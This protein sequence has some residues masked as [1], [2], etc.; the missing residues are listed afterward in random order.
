MTR[1]LAQQYTEPLS[2]TAQLRVLHTGGS[3]RFL[4]Q[5]PLGT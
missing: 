4:S 5:P 3:S 2:R 1:L